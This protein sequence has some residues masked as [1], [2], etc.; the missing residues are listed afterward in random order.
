MFYRYNRDD[1]TTKIPV[2]K[3]KTMWKELPS[4]ITAAMYNPFT[5]HINYFIGHYYYQL[6]R[7]NKVCIS[8]SYFI[9]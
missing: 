3:S 5:Y 2:H 7:Y 6:N 4:G 9:Y 8:L 1:R